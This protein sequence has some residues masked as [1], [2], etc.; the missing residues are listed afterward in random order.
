MILRLTECE[1]LRKAAIITVMII[2]A[3]E[4]C[5]SVWPPKYQV[6]AYSDYYIAPFTILMEILQYMCSIGV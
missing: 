4:T 3:S 5:M 1:R 6:H 2:L